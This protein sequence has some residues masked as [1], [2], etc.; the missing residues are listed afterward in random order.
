[1][2]FSTSVSVSKARLCCVTSEPHIAVSH[3]AQVCSASSKVC[4]GSRS[5]SR[6]TALH[7]KAQGSRLPPAGGASIS[8]SPRQGKSITSL[9]PTL[10]WPAPV[11]WLHPTPETERR[12]MGKPR[13]FLLTMRVGRRPVDS[14]LQD[15]L[16]VNL[17]TYSCS[18]PL[19]EEAGGGLSSLLL[20]HLA[21]P[22]PVRNQ[23]PRWVSRPFAKFC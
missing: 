8:G 2:W 10:H 19:L 12:T 13:K 5:F 16:T 23:C 3:T 15:M 22:P 1:M 17:W 9:P 18:R 7:A 20:S 11:T 6:A 21:V 14:C 4:R